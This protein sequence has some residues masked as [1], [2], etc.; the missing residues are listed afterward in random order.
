MT[1][2][3][4]NIYKWLEWVIMGDRPFSFVEN[5]FTKTNLE[6]ILRTTLMKYLEKLQSWVVCRDYNKMHHP[7]YV[8]SYFR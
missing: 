2:K 5:S 1:K 7:Q 4:I 3:A 8:R 6:S